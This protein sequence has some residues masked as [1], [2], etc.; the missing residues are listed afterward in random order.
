[1]VTV[2]ARRVGDWMAL[3]MYSNGGLAR[4][5]WKQLEWYDQCNR[6]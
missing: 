3:N 2:I 1:M 6:L 4:E 5:S